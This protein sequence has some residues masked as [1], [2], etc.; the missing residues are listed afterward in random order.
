M[1]LPS[2]GGWGPREGVTA[3]AFGA[4]GLGASQGV[5]TAVVYGVMVLVATLP[6]AAVLVVVM[7]PSYPASGT[8]VEPPASGREPH[9]PDRPYTLLE[10]RPVDRRLPRQRGAAAPRAVQRRR[11]RP[12]RRRARLLRRDPGRRGHRADRQ[13]AAAG[14]LA[15]PPRRADGARAAAVADQGHRDRAGGA[16]PRRRLLH[17]RRHREARLLRE[18]PRGRRPLAT[19]TGGDRRRRRPA[20]G[21]ARDS[22]RTSASAACSG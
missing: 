20:G 10:L 12:G 2:V 5:T 17:R 8:A 1:V 11:L 15:G 19:R 22:A 3:W 18:P 21:D 9:M 14:A 16:R 4:A 13:P 7:V 6:G